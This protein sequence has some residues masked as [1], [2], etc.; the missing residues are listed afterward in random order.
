MNL[1]Q[2]F[3]QS[4]NV[5]DVLKNPFEKECIT[6]VNILIYK[7]RFPPFEIKHIATVVF[8]NGNTEG[9]QNFEAGD[10]TTLVVQIQSFINNLTV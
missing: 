1:S 9:K 4:N 7:S 10:F 3:E 6:D 2:T 5:I 8:K